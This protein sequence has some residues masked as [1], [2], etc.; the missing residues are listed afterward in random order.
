M[1]ADVKKKLSDYQCLQAIFL[2][3]LEVHYYTWFMMTHKVLKLTWWR[4]SGKKTFSCRF[5]FL[6]FLTLLLIAGWTLPAVGR[7]A[8]FYSIPE[9]CVSADWPSDC[10]DLKT[11]PAIVRTVLENGLRISVRANRE[12]KE[13][14]ALYLVVHAG[15]LNETEEQRGVAHFLEH[16]M[17]NGTR[18]FPPGSLIPYLQ[19]SGMEFGRDSNAHT[20]YDST[21]YHLV[22]PD[23]KEKTLKDGL[24]VLSDFAE[25]ATLSDVEIDRERGIILAEKRSRDSEEYQ[26]QVAKGKISY[27]GTRL[28][29]HEVI[30]KQKVLESADHNLLNS[31]YKTWYRPDNMDLVIVG[32]MDPEKTLSLAR[33]TFSPLANPENEPA[34]IPDFGELEKQEFESFYRY[35]P[36]LG[37]TEVSIEKYWNLSLEPDS[38]QVEERE[39]TRYMT[40]MLLE[41]RLEELKEKGNGACTDSSV[42]YGDLQKRIAYTSFTAE[43]S[44]SKLEECIS[45]LDKLV[46]QAYLFGFSEQETKKVQKELQAYLERRVVT[47]KAADSRTIANRIIRHLIS[48]R[49]Y[50]SPRQ[51]LE[52]YGP[53]IQG[54]NRDDLHQAF[55][56][57]WN[58]GNLFISVVGNSGLGQ[59][60]KERVAELYRTSRSKPVY[61]REVEKELHFPY[62][63]VPDAGVVKYA[64]DHHK[65][66]D[67]DII[68]FQNNLVVNFKKTDFEPGSFRLVANFGNGRQS[69]D[70]PGILLLAEET[71]GGSGSGTLSVVDLGKILAGTSVS[72]AFRIDESSFSWSGGGLTKDFEFGVQLLYTLL[73]DPGYKKFA[74]DNSKAEIELLYKSLAH[75]IGGAF[76]LKVQPFLA[77]G[78]KRFG[79]VPWED[80]APL[81][82]ED[83]KTWADNHLTPR[84]LEISV[85]GDI[86]RDQVITM[87]SKYFGHL[88]LTPPVKRWQQSIAF[89][90]KKELTVKVDTDLVKGLCALAWST[91]DFRDI[92]KNR[93]LYLLGLILEDRLREEIREKLGKAYSPS[94]Y[95]YGS[96]VFPGYGYILSQATVDPAELKSTLGVIQSIGLKLGTSGVNDDELARVR[97]PLLSRLKETMAGNDY[98]LYSVLALSSRFPEQLKWPESIISDFSGYSA[99]ELTKLANRYIRDGA[100][101]VVLPDARQRGWDGHGSGSAFGTSNTE[102]LRQ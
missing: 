101:A 85:V 32:D 44:Q 11:D 92:Y 94:V 58:D 33:K 10:S 23:S 30:G 22:L 70:Q 74:F 102:E 60:G 52:I 97:K 1:R 20:S 88:Q 8:P 16:M 4:R 41:D 77:G 38:R 51:E 48:N 25:G 64:V 100:V 53:F 27:R 99:E 84:D 19:Q 18:N 90:R 15:S 69:A 55:K 81:T 12:P 63:S 65:N 37:R 2:A 82:Y 76:P 39:L 6:F 93:G 5:L 71:V 80:L 13:R 3:C 91:D 21:V 45:L 89:P 31:F 35:V 14:V 56:D 47:E 24:L 73:L 50:Q 79:L 54:V 46:R 95:S 9:A 42:S 17:F 36:Q 40:T 59:Q 83:V 62:L 86:D 57:M 66:I 43:T 49:V 26:N 72:L 75:K 98:W 96:R 67:A 7:S 78:D 34:T 87:M 29:G 28:A 61:E 68:R